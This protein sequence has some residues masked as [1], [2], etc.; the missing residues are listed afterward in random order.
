MHISNK[1]PKTVSIGYH[2]EDGDFRLLA[3]L[4]R[5]DDDMT[6]AQFRTLILSTVEYLKITVSNSV[7]YLVREDAPDYIT[8]Q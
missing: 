8:L 3:T 7:E 1:Y 2:R 6:A 4:S 5:V